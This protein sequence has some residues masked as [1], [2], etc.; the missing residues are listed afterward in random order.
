HW[1]AWGKIIETI[2]SGKPGFDAAFD[3]PLFAYLEKNAQT[4][5]VFNQAMLERS[6][7]GFQEF[8]ARIPLGGARTLVDVGGGTGGLLEATLLAHP[9][10]NGVLFDRPRVIEE[11]RRRMNPQLTKRCRFISGD[12]FRV[13]PKL[14]ADV[15]VLRNVLHDCN[16]HRA[17][18]ILRNCR[19]KMS[20]NSKLLIM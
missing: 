3:M 19:A 7:K 8:A 4:A 13:W 12:F 1:Q 17:L 10:L 20:A 15:Y 16:D 5:A 11:A 6:G 14:F 18:R 9:N 2:K